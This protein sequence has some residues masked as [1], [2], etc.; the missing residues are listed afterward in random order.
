MESLLERKSV[1]T[2]LI[3]NVAFHL[4]TN[5]SETSEQMER[6]NKSWLRCSQWFG[7]LFN[8]LLLV[9][10]LKSAEPYI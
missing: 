10:Y 4:E 9:Y 7:E 6:Q 2:I 5:A 8:L 1:V 3:A